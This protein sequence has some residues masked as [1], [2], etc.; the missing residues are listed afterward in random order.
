MKDRL[1]I[2][3]L[4]VVVPAALVY[5]HLPDE[6]GATLY[7]AV[8]LL[9]IPAVLVSVR[10]RGLRPTGPWALIGA[11][12]LMFV[13][14]DTLLAMYGW[15]VDTAPFPWFSDIFYLGS[16]PLLTVGL[17]R[18]ARRR[19]G[20]GERETVIDA[21]IV[22]VGAGMLVWVYFIA[23]AAADTS[24]TPLARAVAGAYPVMDLLLVAMVAR[25][26]FT[27]GRLTP[28]FALLALSYGALLTADV[29][30][31]ITQLVEL[32]L[33][34]TLRLTV[35]CLTYAFGPAALAHPSAVDVIVVRPAGPTLTRGRLALLAGAAL[36]APG[37]L[38]FQTLTAQRVS[39]VV[40]AVG[41]ATLFLLVVLRMAGLVSELD[42]RSAQVEA[43]ARRDA[44]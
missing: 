39:G 34:P 17:G 23:P 1:W 25:L 26:L 9:T 43:L 19:A 36:L 41:S 24:L 32:P 5:P 30:Y 12:L 31:Q 42:A 14:G 38:A 13:T 33:L 40:I 15:T 37:L 16:Y 8:L 18:M 27:S 21:A 6:A 7:G 20:V 44:L 4:A 22:T 35:Y 10:G 2:V 3:V 28:A 11:G 29:V